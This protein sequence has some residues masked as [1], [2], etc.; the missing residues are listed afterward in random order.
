ML[1]IA[2]TK[3]VYVAVKS[4]FTIAGNSITV[5]HQYA[6]EELT[7]FPRILLNWVEEGIQDQKAIGNAIDRS[8]TKGQR[9]LAHLS[10]NVYAKQP[11]AWGLNYITLAKDITKQLIADINT[12]WQGLSSGALKLHRVSQP[13]NLTD[14]ELSLGNIDRARYQFDVYFLYNW[15][16]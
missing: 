15:T 7:T 3:S 2:E 10:V 16:W 14:M 11:N 8:G 4:A 9:S 1:S 6:N 5:G 12:N 13:R